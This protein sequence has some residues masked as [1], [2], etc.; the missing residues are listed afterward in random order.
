MNF[1]TKGKCIWVSALA[2]LALCTTA[3]GQQRTL[4]DPAS[5]F[6][7]PEI[8][9]WELTLGGSG[10]SAHD[11]SGGRGDVTGSLGYYF[12]PN[13]ALSIRQGIG[14]SDFGGGS[15]WS[16]ATRGALDYHFNLDRLRPFV[17]VNFGGIYGDGVTDTFAA[18]LEAGLK[19][20]V[21]PRTFIMGLVEWQWLFKEARDIDDTFDD[22]QFIYSLAIGFN[23]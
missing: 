15:S 12:T 21:Q 23:F 2:T 9:D 8:G 17:G 22:G 11:F 14:F 1:V 5:G 3:Y 20:Y 16:G 7:G 4:G 6:F 10:S 18:G 13:W 19:Y